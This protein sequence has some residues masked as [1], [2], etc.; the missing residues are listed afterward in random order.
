MKTKKYY[1]I[2]TLAAGILSVPALGQPE[3]PLPEDTPFLLGRTHPALTGINKL[4][5]V[6]IPPD[7]EPGKEGLIWNELQT[8]IQTK[9]KQA[10]LKI[11]HP[12]QEKN[13]AVFFDFPE[14]RVYINILKLK[15]SPL[16]VFHTQTSLART[17][18]LTKDHKLFL[19]ADVW[20]VLPVMQ[21][22]SAQT[23]PSTVTDIVLQQV[24][25]F[26]TAWRAANPEGIQPSD[27]S[28][29]NTPAQKQAQITDKQQASEHKYI[30]SKNS[31]VFHNP[32]C[33]SAKLIAPENMIGYSSREEAINA[34]KRPCKLCKP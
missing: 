1:L 10:G 22:V 19:K 33:R 31:E 6:I 7:A 14:L 15:D 26:I 27:T 20:N 24:E 28:N 4:Y 17:V 18:Y 2:L 13:T 9:L 16:Y 29:I 11:L 34:S 8:K 30:A 23:M 3:P 21:A 32:T 12:L 25:G 5:V